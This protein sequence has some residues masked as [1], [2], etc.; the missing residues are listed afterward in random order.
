M[1]FTELN[2]SGYDYNDPFYNA[3]FE[4]LLAKIVVCYNLMI[5][6]NVNLNNDENII[7]DALLTK[8]LKNNLVRRNVGLLDFLFDREVPEDNTIG[9]T[10]IKIQTVNTFQD[11]SAYYI[12]E[13]K[14]LDA[15][16]TKGKTGLNAKYIQ[17]GIYRFTSNNYSTYNKTNGM[18]GFLVQV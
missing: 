4:G 2:A 10:D 3:E 6:D 11:T 8:Y 1:M 7:R 9:R 12:I 17:N 16:N 13:C 18:I 14:R 5:S 15:I